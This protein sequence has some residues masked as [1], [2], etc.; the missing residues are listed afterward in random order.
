ML[1]FIQGLHLVVC[2]MILYIL[3]KY[4]RKINALFENDCINKCFN[5]KNTS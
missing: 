5:S 4:Y 2:I 3:L 1:S